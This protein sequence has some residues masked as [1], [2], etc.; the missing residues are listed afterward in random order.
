MQVRFLSGVYNIQR[1]AL[2]F[3]IFL[4][5]DINVYNPSMYQMCTV[6][7][8]SFCLHNGAQCKRRFNYSVASS[9]TD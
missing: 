9:A 2:R 6:L 4:C 8:F 3:F 1:I 7:T 5:G